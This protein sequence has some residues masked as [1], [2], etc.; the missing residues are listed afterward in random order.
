[1]KR[2]RTASVVRIHNLCCRCDPILRWC[3]SWQEATFS[4]LLLLLLLLAAVEEETE[5]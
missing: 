1:M 4:L 2:A 3:S 5:L